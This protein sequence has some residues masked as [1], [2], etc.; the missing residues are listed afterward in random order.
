MAA[1]AMILLFV[2]MLLLIMFKRALRRHKATLNRELALV[3]ATDSFLK[4]LAIVID[5][6][7]R[8]G[9]VKFER[10]IVHGILHE[11]A[12]RIEEIGAE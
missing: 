4:Q 2:C 11:F 3:K 10:E 5:P 12:V 6:I 8:S 9:Q 1:L 7:E